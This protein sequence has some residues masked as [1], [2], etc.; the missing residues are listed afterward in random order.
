MHLKTVKLSIIS[1]YVWSKEPSVR[2]EM[3]AKIFSEF[4]L[5]DDAV[6]HNSIMAMAMHGLDFFTVTMLL[7]PD[8]CLLVY[9]TIY[10]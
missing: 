5:T 8:R 9:Y 1:S 4:L 10:A 6:Q 2:P 7:Q 3:L